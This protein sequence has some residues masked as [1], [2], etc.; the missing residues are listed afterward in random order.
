MRSSF[1]FLVALACTGCDA[2]GLLTLKANE[3]TE[4]AGLPPVLG[5]SAND[6]VAAGT[7]AKNGKYKI[8][9]TF[10]QPTPNQDVSKSDENEL[11]GGLV[12]ATQGK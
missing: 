11:H 4:D 3:T 2:G 12:G 1:V 8:V 7:V 5:P 9:F 10:G 6:M